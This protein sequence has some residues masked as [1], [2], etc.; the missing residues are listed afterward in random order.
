MEYLNELN[1]HQKWNVNTVNVKIDM[2][3]ILKGDNVPCIVRIVELH[4][5]K[6]SVIRAVTV[7]VSGNPLFKRNLTKIAILPIDGNLNV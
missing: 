7:R 1:V 4:P 5:G 6:N 3:E 2:L